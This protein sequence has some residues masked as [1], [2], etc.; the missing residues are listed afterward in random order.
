MFYYIY[1]T[2]FFFLLRWGNA[3]THPLSRG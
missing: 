3:V 2:F 1:I